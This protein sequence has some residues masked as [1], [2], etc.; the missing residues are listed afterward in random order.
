M[1]INRTHMNVNPDFIR[2][3]CVQS[4]HLS[5]WCK[6]K[7]FNCK[8]PVVYICQKLWKL[9][10]SR[11]SYCKNKPAYFFWPI[12]HKVLHGTIMFTW[13]PNVYHCT[14]T[15]VQCKHAV[16]Q[17]DLHT[18][19]TLH[20]TYSYSV[21]ICQISLFLKQISLTLWTIND[22]HID[23]AITIIDTTMWHSKAKNRPQSTW[24]SG[25]NAAGIKRLTQTGIVTFWQVKN[26]DSSIG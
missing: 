21:T 2:R 24:L 25:M 9:A 12:L 4:S 3:G 15:R 16:R 26:S 1:Y 22:L 6:S 5:P 8:F 13:H 18:K 20:P 19:L 11:Q 14:L 17:L 10:G 23:A 7:P